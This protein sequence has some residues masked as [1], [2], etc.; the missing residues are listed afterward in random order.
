MNLFIVHIHESDNPIFWRGPETD[1]SIVKRK[2]IA[3]GILAV[4]VERLK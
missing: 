1:E 2:L 4:F 3:K